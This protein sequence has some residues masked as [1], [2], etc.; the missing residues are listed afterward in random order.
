[1]KVDTEPASPHVSPP[2]D[3]ITT[4]S[5][6]PELMADSLER[7]MEHR[8]G[9]QA[10]PRISDVSSP[11]SNGMSSETLLFTATWDEEGAPV[12][13]RLVAR[14]EPPATDYPIFASYDLD[15]Q[16]KV[17]RLV[18]EHTPV[19]VP[20]TLWFEPDA[21]VLA[22]S[23][24][25]MAGVDGL[26]PPDVLPYTFGDNWVFDAD[27]A[28]RHSIQESAVRALAGIH[29]IT[30]D[31]F[32]LGFL[33]PAMPG[34]N[35]L[36]RL[37]NHWKDYVAWVVHGAGSPLLEECLDWLD[38]RFPTDVGGD[39]LSWGDSRIG[40]MMFKDN[41]VAAV[42]DWEMASVAPPEVDLGWMCYLHLFF[43]DLATDLGAPGL[44]AMFRPVD[45]AESYAKASGR[46]P[47]DLT[48]HIAFAAI[49]HGAIMRRV[50]ERAI[51]FGEAEMPDDIDDLIMHRA[52]LR[53]MVDGTYWPTL[54]L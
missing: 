47:C 9:P 46:A 4:S 3:H 26:V 24:F 11:A 42:L 23:F 39:A 51:H 48:W 13:R 54:A 5:R 41:E 33:E 16:F 30:P 20:E 34:G 53:A 22:G 15:M 18:G 8:L 2:A 43:Q 27:E 38:D 25:V 6:D 7:W 29:S 21:A 12:E 52:T 10:A 49:R 35:S 31:H 28:A 17:M 45:V 36:E 19:P 14:I 50:A 32:D 40:N 37:L 44:P 1:V